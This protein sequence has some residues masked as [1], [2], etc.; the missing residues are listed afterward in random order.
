MAKIL[1]VEDNSAVRDLLRHILTTEEME[2]VTVEDGEA[3]LKR[4]RSDAGSFDFVLLDLMLPGMDGTS[5]CQEIRKGAAGSANTD[6]PIL[7]LTARDNE[8]SVVVGLEVGADD[9]ITKP[10]SPRELTIRM[11]AHLRR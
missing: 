3:A 6:L 1:L 10:F 9:Y 4:L 11:R 8:T 5:V 7:M 2:A